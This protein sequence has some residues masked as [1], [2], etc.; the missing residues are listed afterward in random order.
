MFIRKGAGVKFKGHKALLRHGEGAGKAE[1]RGGRKT[2]AGVIIGVPHH[3]DAR[4]PDQRSGGEDA[5][6][7]ELC[8]DAFSLKFRKHGHGREGQKT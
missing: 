3:H 4:R 8:P 6:A 1:A 7:D 2:E 5:L